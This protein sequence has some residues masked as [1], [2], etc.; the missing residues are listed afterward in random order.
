MS[1]YKR[2]FGSKR[3]HGL[4]LLSSSLGSVHLTLEHELHK[5]MYTGFFNKWKTFEISYNLKNYFL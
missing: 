5:S 2:A 3:G 4:Q 1:S